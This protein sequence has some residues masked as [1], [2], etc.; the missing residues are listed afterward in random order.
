MRPG[1]RRCDLESI[2]SNERNPELHERMMLELLEKAQR[3]RDDLKE[4]LKA[5]RTQNTNLALDVEG[6]K[7]DLEKI[8]KLERVV[9]AT[10][11]IQGW[12]GMVPDPA[13]LAAVQVMVKELDQALKAITWGI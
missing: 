8:K 5:E 3:E 2:P 9:R 13:A 11:A 6:L 1:T 10:R 12:V 7:R 4:K